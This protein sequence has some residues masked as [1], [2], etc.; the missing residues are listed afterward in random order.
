MEIDLKKEIQKLKE[1]N[2]FLTK[3]IKEAPACIHI[4]KVDQNGHN[5][6]VW[7]NDKYEELLG[8]TIDER[9]KIG[10]ADE[11]SGIYHKEDLEVIQRAVK[12]AFEN[13]DREESIIFRYFRKNGELRWIYLQ[14]K[15][16][17]YQNDPNHILSIGFDVTE[18]LVINQYQL[19]LYNKEITQLKN[20]LKIYN[21]TKVE[22]EIIKKL[23][24]GKTTKQIAEQRNRSY[25]TI[26][27]HKRNIF[28]KLQLKKIN[29]LVAFAKETG[30]D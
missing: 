22:K 3:L 4:N 10:F 17:T 30:L 11:K 15:A 29:E 18:K 1:D 12:I 28:K 13:K 7:A 27:N 14:S 5:M 23:A 24:S 6:P 21:L 19:E 26:N 16:I 9:K 20:Q 8:Y 25:D 2:L